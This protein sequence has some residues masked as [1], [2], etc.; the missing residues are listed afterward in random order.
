MSLYECDRPGC[1]WR[2]PD[3]RYGFADAGASYHY[4][5]AAHERTDP[6]ANA[7]EARDCQGEWER[8]VADSGDLR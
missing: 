1:D 8:D 4:H 2:N 5:L 3:W 6:N 7:D